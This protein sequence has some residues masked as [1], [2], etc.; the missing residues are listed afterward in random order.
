MKCMHR[1]TILP[2]SLAFVTILKTAILRNCNGYQCVYCISFTISSSNTFRSDKYLASNALDAS[3]N[4]SRPPCTEYPLMASDFTQ[5]CKMSTGF[6]KV[7]KIKFHAITLSDYQV[8]YKRTVRS[9]EDN[10]CIFATY[11]ANSPQTTSPQGA[12]DSPQSSSGTTFIN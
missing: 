8:L 5:N 1:I 9:V 12:Y 3:K 11:V 2:R 10:Q 4:P 6:S 7:A